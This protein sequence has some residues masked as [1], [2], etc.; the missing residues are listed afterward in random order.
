MIELRRTA[1]GV[2]LV[3]TDD[4]D[5]GDKSELVSLSLGRTDCFTTEVSVAGCDVTITAPLTAGTTGS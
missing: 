2:V 5:E 1:M 3:E 4:E